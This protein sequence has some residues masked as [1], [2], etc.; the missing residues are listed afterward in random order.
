MKLTVGSIWKDR[1]GRTYVVLD[2][3]LPGDYSVLA[4]GDKNVL[5]KYRKE[6]FFT[7]PDFPHE[8]DLVEKV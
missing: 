6:G 7:H 5:Y 8:R 3:G 4:M 2:V 1:K